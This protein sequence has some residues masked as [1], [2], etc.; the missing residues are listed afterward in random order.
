MQISRSTVALFPAYK[1][2]SECEY[3]EK[4][5]DFKQKMAEIMKK[6]G[7]EEVIPNKRETRSQSKKKEESKKA[8]E[9][10]SEGEEDLEL[11]QI[12]DHYQRNTKGCFDWIMP[13]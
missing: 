11:N 2:T 13:F 12:T 5:K 9:E 8:A 4:P 3:N 10:E 1:P 7:K 6:E